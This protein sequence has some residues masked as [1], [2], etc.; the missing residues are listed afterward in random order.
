MSDSIQQTKP[1]QAKPGKSRRK[2]R[3]LVL[4]AIYRR[5]L[6]GDGELCQM[7][8]DL[9][10][11][12]D[13]ERA[14]QTYFQE[15]L[16]GVMENVAA[17]DQR[18]SEFLDRSTVELSPIEH[19]ILCIAA[20]ELIHDMSIPYRVVINEGVE[21]AKSYGGPSSGKFVNGVLGAIFKNMAPEE[22]ASNAD[23]KKE[24]S[25]DKDADKTAE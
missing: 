19:G 23:A 2:S 24:K 13:F 12:E 9:A 22:A 11:D 16:Q 6:N 4:K 3:E 25:A 20:Y 1:K 17:L 5:F 7:I 15:L 14:D 21:L 8:S 18:L 10:D